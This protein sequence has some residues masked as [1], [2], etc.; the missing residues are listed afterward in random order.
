MFSRC[1]SR[2]M[3]ARQEALSPNRTSE[4]ATISN[5]VP[6]SSIASIIQPFSTSR[7]QS[8]PSVSGSRINALFPVDGYT[9]FWSTCPEV[10]SHLGLSDRTLRPNH[11]LRNPTYSYQDAPDGTQS[12]KGH[13]PKDSYNFGNYPQGGFF[14]YAPGPASVD[15]RTAKEATFGYSVYFPEGFAFNMG[16]K[17]PRLYGGDSDDQAIGCSGGRRD[18]A[19]FSVRLMWRTAGAGEL[20]TYLPPG[21][22]ANDHLCTIPPFSECNPTYG[23]S[24]GRGS[25][26]FVTGGW[27]VVSERVRLNDPGTPNGEIELFV[28]GVS[29]INV[30]GLVLCDAS[31]YGKFRGIQGQTFFGGSSKQWA[32]PKDQ[33]IYFADFSVSIIQTS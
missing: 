20:Y 10:P 14:F 33:G 7:R 18:T 1:I 5:L 16:G 25:F 11:V 6:W 19:C 31:G 15:L 4:L 13:F 21:F 3:H 30:G 23:A 29:V 22:S 17:L 12:M 32:S 28:N 8:S 2:D 27:T 24:V 9:S 26:Q